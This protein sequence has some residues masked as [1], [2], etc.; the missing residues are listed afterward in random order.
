MR[1]N[2]Y[3]SVREVKQQI[4]SGQIGPKMLLMEPSTGEWAEAFLLPALRPLFLQRAMRVGVV[5]PLDPFGHTAFSQADLAGRWMAAA[6]FGVNPE[7]EVEIEWDGWKAVVAEAE[8]AALNPSSGIEGLVKF[9]VAGLGAYLACKYV[10]NSRVVNPRDPVARNEICR[11]DGGRCR[12]CG[13]TV[14]CAHAHLDHRHPKS[15]GGKDTYGNL[16]TAHPS[17]NQ[18]K[19][20]KT[21]PEFNRWL[22]DQQRGT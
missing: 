6:R 21:M 13:K 7:R 22:A 4:L 8:L 11:R 17:C 10:E 2:N 1:P 9:A 14:S 16:Q 15:R 18:S 19:G 20:A 3:L 5:R 12:I